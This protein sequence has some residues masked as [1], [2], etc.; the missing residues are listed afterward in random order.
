MQTPVPRLSIAMPV[1]NFAEY[2]PAT[3]ESIAT[4]QRIA[5]V[6]LVVFDGGSTDNTREVVESYRP[7]IPLLKYIKADTRGGIDRDLASAVARC[8]GKFVWFFSGDDIMRTGAIDW[9]LDHQGEH[10]DLILC[11]HYE[12]STDF[13]RW[14][15]YP[16]LDGPARVFELSWSEH[17]KNY[18]LLAKSSE[19]FFSF[20]G[21]IIIRR[22]TWH[23]EPFPEDFDGTCW[24]HAARLCRRATK[25]SFIVSFNPEPLLYRRPENDSFLSRGLVERLRLGIAGYKRIADEI[26]GK[27]SIEAKAIGRIL[28]EEFNVW[29]MLTG[30]FVANL[31]PDKED[32]A[33]NARMLQ[34]I[35]CSWTL[36]DLRTRLYYARTTPEDFAYRNPERTAQLEVLYGVKFVPQ[37]KMKTVLEKYKQPYKNLNNV[38]A[39]AIAAIPQ[40]GS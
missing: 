30:K 18:S 13:D 39:R 27:S 6:E 10:H 40:H 20:I 1:Y 32:G 9:A 38:G 36:R 25:G 11:R 2:L 17:R 4:Q 15:D 37:R 5:E 8:S 35:Y 3:L 14:Y 31:A 21:G 28:R 34:L 23:A 19:A 26:F 22:S 7:R 24:A 16:V 33:L 29:Q 12:W